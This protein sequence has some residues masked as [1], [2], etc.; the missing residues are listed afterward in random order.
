MFLSFLL[1]FAARGQEASY[2]WVLY[3]QITHMTPQE[4][5]FV[6][7]AEYFLSPEEFVRSERW[8]ISA[9]SRDYAGFH[10]PTLDELSRYTR[11]Q[12]P[13]NLFATWQAIDPDVDRVMQRILTERCTKLETALREVLV[14]AT[15]VHQIEA[16]FSWCNVPSLAAIAAEFDLPVVH[17]ELGPLRAPCYHWTAYFD[18]SGVNGNTEAQRRFE[19]FQ[20][21]READ[22]PPL[23]STQEMRSLLVINPAL[24]EPMPDPDFAIGLPLQVENDTNIIAFANGWSNDRL[25]AAASAIYGRDMTLLRKHPGGLRDYSDEQ[26]SIDRSTNSIDFINRCARIATINSSVGL[27]ALLFDRETVFLGDNPCAFAALNSLD[28]LAT[29]RSQGNRLPALNFLLFGYLIPYEFLFDPDYLRWRLSGP[30]E[31]EIYRFHLGYVKQ[32]QRSIAEGPRLGAAELCLVDRGLFKF[33]QMQAR[34]LGRRADALE[35][36]ADALERQCASLGKTLENTQ[37]SWSWRLTSPLR[38]IRQACE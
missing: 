29:D 24:R 10:I 37:N 12:L 14:E 8:D 30:S 38:W 6:G 28:Q 7:S 2:L 33:W 13:D 22:E 21:N 25:I 23:L 4:V 27:E 32:R 31:I 3:K 1:P 36:R 5:A 35:G 34:A 26:A 9:H 16:L 11:Y 18:F 19:R 15:A 20:A 17:A